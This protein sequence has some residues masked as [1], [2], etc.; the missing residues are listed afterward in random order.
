MSKK[1][2]LAMR[3]DGSALW[4]FLQS[5]CD[6]NKLRLTQQA[7]NSMDKPSYH[8]KPKVSLHR[9]LDVAHS[10]FLS[11]VRAI[12]C[13]SKYLKTVMQSK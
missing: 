7:I 2:D 13:F 3:E 10:T 6:D 5:G 8:G 4:L 1:I 12:I 11:N 9:L